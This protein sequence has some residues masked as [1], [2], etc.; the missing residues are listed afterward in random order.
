[1]KTI[2]NAHNEGEKHLLDA[3]YL[4]GLTLISITR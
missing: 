2:D 1:M 3:L 4:E